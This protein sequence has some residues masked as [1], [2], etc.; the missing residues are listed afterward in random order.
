MTNDQ[1]DGIGGI[2]GLS[3]IIFLI[4]GVIHLGDIEDR[5][6]AERIAIVQKNTST[7]NVVTNIPIYSL[8]L[9]NEISGHLSGSSDGIFILGFG[10]MSGSVSGEV[11][12][13]SL[14]YFYKDTKG[15][16]VILSK[17]DAEATPLVPSAEKPHLE[18]TSQITKVFNAINENKIIS[19]RLFVPMNYKLLGD[20]KK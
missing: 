2:I 11:S 17:V 9:N 3:C 16:G 8:S 6:E 13:K 4:W 20:F 10:G 5:K 7:S 14:Y 15:G 19:Q 1:K 18:V 12:E